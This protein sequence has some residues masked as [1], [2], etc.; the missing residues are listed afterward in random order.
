[1]MISAETS[2]KL[3]L[4]FL[5]DAGDEASA[6]G[7]LSASDSDD[8]WFVVGPTVANEAP[9]PIRRTFYMFTRKADAEIVGIGYSIEFEPDEDLEAAWRR[10]AAPAAITAWKQRPQVTPSAATLDLYATLRGGVINLPEH[11]VAY[12][13]AILGLSDLQQQN[14]IAVERQGTWKISSALTPILDFS[15]QNGRVSFIS[16]RP[17]D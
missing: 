4:V 10:Q 5:T 15:R 6:R 17:P 9:G 8:N 7:L 2:K 1:M 11:A 3:A 12:A 16:R 13:G 14:L